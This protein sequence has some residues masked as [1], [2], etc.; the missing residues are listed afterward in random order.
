MHPATSTTDDSLEEEFQKCLSNVASKHGV[1][2]QGKYK[3]WAS[4][5]KC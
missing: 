1:I 3:T 4:K 2:D 5:R